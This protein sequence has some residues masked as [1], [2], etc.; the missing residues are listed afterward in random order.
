MVGDV[1]LKH[2]IKLS[3]YV[4]AA[5][6]DDGH[7]M[8]L[9][10]AVDARVGLQIGFDRCRWGVPDDGVS[11]GQREPVRGCF[12]LD[13]EDARMLAG[14]KPR[15]DIAALVEGHLA[16]DDVAADLLFLQGLPQ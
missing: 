4:A 8:L 14:L 12:W 13:Q 7:S 10:R 3:F 2:M 6:V 1:T 11:F 16:V 5:N 15:D 9:T